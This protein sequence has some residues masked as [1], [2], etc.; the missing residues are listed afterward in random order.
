MPK[1][2]TTAVP[3]ADLPEPK[4]DWYR[5]RVARKH[6]LSGQV[7][8]LIPLRGGRKSIEVPR[9]L[10]PSASTCLAYDI[11]LVP[12]GSNDDASDGS[13]EYLL[14][15][16][17]PMTIHRRRSFTENGVRK[18]KRV[19]LTKLERIPAANKKERRDVAPALV[20]NEDFYELLVHYDAKHLMGLK[21]SV[22]KKMAEVVR[23]HSSAVALWPALT[24]VAGVADQA[25]A[26]PDLESRQRSDSPALRL[27]REMRELF[28]ESGV[29]NFSSMQILGDT[30]A[31]EDLKTWGV[32]DS[33][34]TF[35]DIAQLE[36]RLVDEL[37]PKVQL[38]HFDSAHDDF[39]TFASQQTD[40]TILCGD[41]QTLLDAKACGL[42][43]VF[44]WTD[45][46][47]GNLGDRF[48]LLRPERMDLQELL[49]LGGSSTHLCLCGDTD[50]RLAFRE[51]LPMHGFSLL[52]DTVGLTGAHAWPEVAWQHGVSEDII[53]GT[54]QHIEVL[55]LT[56]W[57][58]LP[59]VISASDLKRTIVLCATEDLRRS[60]MAA[61]ST[62]AAPVS[63]VPRKNAVFAHHITGRIGPVQDVGHHHARI[64]DAQVPNREL[65]RGD[66]ELFTKFLGTR[67]ETVVAIVDSNTPRVAL[68]SALKHS[69]KKFKVLIA[70]GTRTSLA[71][72]PDDYDYAVSARTKQ[73]V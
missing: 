17:A 15:A 28:V 69:E 6:G 48:T 11:S 34:L 35:A 12:D 21:P 63:D 27:Y 59:R 64:F 2:M 41:Y 36:Q 65:R 55:S 54:M 44:H 42:R 3:P 46:L 24:A 39:Y 26:H 47:P 8:S 30:P 33:A 1:T 72:L 38:H 51:R 18:R 13:G 29:V 70:P 52:F 7:Y 58:R 50:A 57:Q 31:L 20:G 37:A 9:A 49:F 56:S 62:P 14:H 32:L 71:R 43:S 73:L 40:T 10:L 68:L 19:L 53:N 25:P 5:K 23:A 16:V 4:G 60:A 22:W 66:I 61:L 45:A 67:R